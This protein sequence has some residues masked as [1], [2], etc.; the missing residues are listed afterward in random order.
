MYSANIRCSLNVNWIKLFDSFVQVF[1]VFT[2]F[3]SIAL[4]ITERRLEISNYHV[5]LSVSL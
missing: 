4:L 3:L 2:D 5:D 1:Y